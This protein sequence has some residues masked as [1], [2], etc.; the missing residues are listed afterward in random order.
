MAH[1]LIRST[2]ASFTGATLGAVVLSV[3]TVHAQQAPSPP[4][5]EPAERVVR[6]SPFV[7]D[8]SK[9]VGYLAS[10]TLA[11]SRLNTALKDT[12]ATISVLTSEFLSDLAAFKFDEAL[13]YAVNVEKDYDDFRETINENATYQ[14]YQVFRVRGL[15]ATI[16]RNYFGWAGRAIPSESAFV[17][18]IEDSRGPNSVL[19]GIASPGGVINVNTKQALIGRE[20]RQVT[21]TVGS[22]DSKRA[23][24]DMNQPLIANK[25]AARMILVYNRDNGFRHFAF[26]EHQRALL[27]AKYQ[28]TDRTRFRVD[29]ERGQYRSNTPRA[30]NLDNAYLKWHAAGRPT[31][32]TVPAA[33][34]RTLLG[35]NQN[36]TAATQPQVTYIS[37]DDRA[38]SMRGVLVTTGAI[39]PGQAGILAENGVIT[40]KSLTDY[41]INIAGPS[42]DRFTRYG[43]FTAIA[44][45]QLAHNI[46]LE[47]GY[48]HVGMTLD[49]RD[50]RGANSLKGDPNALL[51]TGAANPRAGQLYLDTNW[52]RTVRDDQIDIGR[53]ALSAEFDG[54]KWGHYRMGLLGEYEESFIG[55]TTLREF[56]VDS[57]TGAPAFNPAAANAQNQV[58][59]RTYVTEGDWRNYYVSGPTGSAGGLIQNMIEPVTGRTLSSAWYNQTFPNHFYYTNQTGMAVVQASYFQKRLI[60]GAGIRRDS[61]EEHRLARWTNPGSGI[62]EVSR[63]PARADPGQD[64]QFTRLLGTTSSFGLVYHLTRQVSLYYNRADNLAIP[65]KGQNRLPPSGEPGNLLRVPPP[66]GVGEDIGVGVEFLDG[67]IHAKAVYYTTSAENQ[68]TTSPGGMRNANTR[69][70]RALLEGGYITQEEHERRTDVGGHGL[71]D[72]VSEGWELQVTANP[73]KQWRFVVNHAIADAVD[74]NKF[75]EWGNW[76]SLTT[77]YLSAFPVNSIVTS[78]G[79]TIADEIRVYEDEL[80]AQTRSSG[81]GKLGNRKSKTSMVTRYNLASGPLSGAYVGAAYRHQS[82][83]FTGV[84]ASLQPVYGNS[85]WTADL[86]AGYTVPKMRDG[87][88]L[89]FQ[90]NVYNVFDKRDPL[91]IRYDANGA[92]YRHVVQPPTTWRLTTT[93]DF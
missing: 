59:R 56:W 17:D 73:T 18:R 47:L 5:E 7:V 48:N 72:Y 54:G 51:L 37:N 58:R 63:D 27:T 22:F 50:P 46:Y 81:I 35:L 65:E 70:M 67:K 86:M 78:S 92:V 87:R 71:F 85:F 53:A 44:E 19:F 11:G 10:S 64:E 26:E 3:V 93:F 80:D 33:A 82:K 34:Q 91:V 74:D 77:Q 55:S 15:P 9:D 16:S 68:S 41:S 69:I 28:I 62:P 79:D 90:L 24:L 76:A 39:P 2:L 83:M 89:S 60:A 30:Y 25:L 66:E 49:S 29:F 1:G 40:D 75:L 61:V 13:S 57:A 45:H 12:A 21:A 6:L 31:F 32:T 36:A 20:L 42:G 4:S 88:K 38:L 43:I 8:D 23:A 52:F 84:D 14:D